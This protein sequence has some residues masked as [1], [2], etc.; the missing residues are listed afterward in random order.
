[1]KQIEWDDVQKIVLSGYGRLPYSAY[2][3]WR[4]LPGD[5]APRKPWLRDLAR[6]TATRVDVNDQ[7]ASDEVGMPDDEA[8]LVYPT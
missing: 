6:S 1:M 2:I 8:L 7:G 5:L 3:L 4:F